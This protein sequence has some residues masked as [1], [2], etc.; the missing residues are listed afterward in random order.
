MTKKDRPMVQHHYGRP[1]SAE[2][3]E[4]TITNLIRPKTRVGPKGSSPYL[5]LQVNI[6]GRT[7]TF[8]L[9]FDALL[10]HGIGG[11]AAV[12]VLRSIQ[13]TLEDLVRSLKSRQEIE[14]HST[15]DH[16]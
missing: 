16:H 7:R 11:P 13:S 3:P 5:E 6:E 2:P 10:S 9:T 4:A 12:E 15:E 8:A 1:G 14:S